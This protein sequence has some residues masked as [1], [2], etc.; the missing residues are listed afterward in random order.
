MFRISTLLAAITL[1]T[2][3][4]AAA[5]RVVGEIRDADTGK[6]I[7]ARIYIQ[8][9]AGKWLF[10]DS[11][12]NKGTA[13]RY[14]KQNRKNPKS[15]EMHTTLSAHPFSIELE[16]GNYTVTVE[17]GKEYL[18]TESQIKVTAGMKRLKLILKRWIN[19]AERGW[20]SGDTHVHRTLEELP[21]LMQA[22]DLNV[23]FPLVYWVTRAFDPPASGNKN[24][25]GGIPSELIL[26]D[27]TH[28]IYPRN[29]EYEIFTVNGKRHPLGAVFVLNH[30]EP[31][32]MGAPPVAPIARQA[33]AEGA[34]LELDKHNWEW[35]MMLVPVM[36]VDLF[37]LSN[38]HVWRT[39]FGFRNFGLDAP[40]YMGLNPIGKW[41]ERDWL[42]YGFKNY[43]AL[44]NSG[45]PLRVTA[46]NA[47]GVHP[48]PLGFG[49]VY[50]HL[51]DGFSYDK[52]VAGLNAGRSFV[53]TGPMLMAQANGND[54]GT[55]LNATAGSTVRI[56]GNLR[57]DHLPGG[58]EIIRNGDI[59]KRIAS[60]P[61]QLANGSYGF[62]FEADIE[63]EESSWLAVRYLETRKNGRLRFAHSN[64][65]HVTVKG[66]PLRPKREEVEFL[67]QRMETQ[68]ARSSEVLPKAAMD[69]YRSALKIY[70][71]K[72]K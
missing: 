55:A 29:T 70:R 59:V 46:G 31:L 25:T 34:L 32:T 13:V 44:L 10:P 8:D 3:S 68:I 60:Q 56:T 49:R 52:W 36:S 64:P 57:S 18:A 48:V 61:E 30:R 5:L 20:Y 4:P 22:E 19:M 69:E 38:N 41:T 66:K 35:S 47:N 72:L 15:V 33:R 42:L 17:R 63:I 45:F 6:L 12:S 23:S 58:I 50:V 51:P 24:L 16:P 27:S 53:T 2:A 54:P 26:L 28:V 43:Y 40:N 39:E 62:R 1:F 65:W 11:N 71:K 37:E 21:N 7:P 9:A 67:I 14:E